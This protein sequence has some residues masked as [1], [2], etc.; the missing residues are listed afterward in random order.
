M[1]IKEEREE[2]RIQRK[3]ADED[4]KEDEI[5]AEEAKADKPNEAETKE[6]LKEYVDLSNYSS[7]FCHHQENSMLLKTMIGDYHSLYAKLYT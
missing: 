7:Y 1:G 6:D 2:G 4:T 5:T 3:D